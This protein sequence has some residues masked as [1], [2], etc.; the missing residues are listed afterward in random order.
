MYA[1]HAISPQHATA[2]LNG[3]DSSR[4]RYGLPALGMFPYAQGFS[5]K[6]CKISAAVSDNSS[7]SN[8]IIHTFATS[9]T[10]R[11]I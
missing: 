7:S 1:T 10:N 6:V 3:L 11:T 8:N 2:H 9:S 4:V 5:K